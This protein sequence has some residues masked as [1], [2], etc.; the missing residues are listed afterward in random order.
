MQDC[1]GGNGYKKAPY[2]IGDSA[3]CTLQNQKFHTMEIN[4]DCNLVFMDKTE[5][6]NDSLEQIGSGFSMP[7][8]SIPIGS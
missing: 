7:M 4:R 1:K 5:K 2:P 6:V 8:E 3:L